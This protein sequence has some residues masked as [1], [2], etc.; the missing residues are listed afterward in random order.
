MS[1]ICFVSYEIHPTVMGGC[2]VLLYNAVHKL[3]PEGHEIV[4]LLDITDPQFQQ[5]T[6]VDRLNLPNADH[7]HAYLLNALAAHSDF[8]LLHF[9]SSYEYQSY[10]FHV[11]LQKICKLEKLDTIEFVDY[12]G[13]GY[14]ALCSK[15]AGLA[16]QDIHIA[17]RLHNS[18]ELIDREQPGNFHDQSR[19][20]MYNLEHHAL[21]LAETV[22]YPSK[23]YLAYAYQPYYEKWFGRLEWSQPPLLN[24]LP[25]MKM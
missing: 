14:A 4:F 9:S 3:L 16:Y 6:S 18:M 21:R 17:V 11:A 2:G 20:L 10:R 5:F 7:C 23:N 22:L 24:V 25:S 1:R 8:E 15:I 13:I 12:C 19:Y